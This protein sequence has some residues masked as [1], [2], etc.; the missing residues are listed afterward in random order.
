MPMSTTLRS[1]SCGSR[2]ERPTRIWAMISLAVICRFRPATPLAQ[3][4]Q[5]MAQPTWVE[6]HW[7]HAGL[8]LGGG[9]AAVG[10]ARRRLVVVV[11]HRGGGVGVHAGVVGEVRRVVTHVSDPDAAWR[12][13]RAKP[14]GTAADAG[15]EHRLD[16]GAVL[17]AD[18]QLAGRVEGAALGRDLHRGADAFGDETLAQRG[19]QIAHRRR[20]DDAARVD[21]AEHLLAVEGTARPSSARRWPTPRACARAG[22]GRSRARRCRS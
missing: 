12:N 2:R 11:I 13:R 7:V 19:R 8:R 21:P 1:C 4:I 18:E 10:V 6:M 9:R 17:H 22:P 14:V 5:P 15:D 20:V 16:G 3:K